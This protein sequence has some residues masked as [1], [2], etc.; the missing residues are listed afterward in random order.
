MAKPRSLVLLASLALTTYG[1]VGCEKSGGG[2]T[3][4]NAYA[5]L[6]ITLPDL[7]DDDITLTS[8]TANDVHLLA[9][10]AIW[11]VPCTAELAKMVGMHD[12]L[13]DKGL[14]LYA[15]SID[16]PDTISR[17]PG[18]AS[19]ERWQF[20]VLYDSATE[21]M[22]RYNPKGD[23]PFYVILDADGNIIKTHQGYVK[24]DVVELEK[25]L[26]ARLESASGAP[27]EDA[28]AEDA[29]AEDAPADAAPGTDAPA[30]D[31]PATDA[32]EVPAL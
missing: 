10:W 1:L 22:G 17:V 24:G 23:I 27:A 6:D 4:P 11:C 9:F 16:G 14:H 20:P 31:A 3:N 13:K 8:A 25:F 30:E 26:T 12:R 2:T 18:F 15:V 29:P 19:Q 32:A 21:I 5:E 28:P 7:E